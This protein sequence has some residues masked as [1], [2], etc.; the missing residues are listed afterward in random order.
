M[1][2]DIMTPDQ[3]E[4]AASP[5]AKQTLIDR[6]DLASKLHDAEIAFSKRMADFANGAAIS[7]LSSGVAGGAAAAWAILRSR[8]RTAADAEVFTKTLRDTF[9]NQPTHSYQELLPAIDDLVQNTLVATGRRAAPLMEKIEKLHQ[10]SA[11][12]GTHSHTLE[13]AHHEVTNEAAALLRRVFTRSPL[14]GTA[15]VVA[16]TV[17]AGVVGQ[18]IYKSLNPHGREEIALLAQDCQRLE[19]LSR[20]AEKAS[21]SFT[22][23][24]DTARAESETLISR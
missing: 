23:R 8:K 6:S 14:K 3:Q 4:L 1:T 13:A 15:S 19:A 16:S 9:A 10:L 20:E 11:Q 22:K 17:V 2:K 18:M 5:M 24:L 7:S 21:G 12:S